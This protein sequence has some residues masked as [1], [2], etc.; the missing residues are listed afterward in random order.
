MIEYC[1]ELRADSHTATESG[2]GSES[3][4]TDISGWTE[5]SGEDVE[6]VEVVTQGTGEVGAKD[7]AEGKS[8][9][10]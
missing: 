4:G 8:L 2:E 7:G 10:S 5:I 6:K 9:M 1:G 3:T